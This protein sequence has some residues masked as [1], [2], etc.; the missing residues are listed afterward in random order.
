MKLRLFLVLWLA[1]SGTASAAEATQFRLYL[2]DGT[3]VVSYGEFAR[4]GDRVIFSFL[5]G[6]GAEPRLHTATLPAAAI[7]WART[8]RYAVSA[9]HQWYAQTRGEED[10]RRLSDEVATVLNTLVMTRDGARALDMA[11]QVR[12]TLAA[13]PREHYGYRERDVRDILA[14]LDEAIAAIRGAAGANS[15]EVALVAEIP[16]TPLEPVATM[17][18][19]SEQVGQA[20]GVARLTESAAERVALYQS[21]LQLLADEGAVLPVDEAASFRKF[22]ETAIRTEQA[23][24][25]RYSGMTKRLMTDAT[26]AAARAQIADVRR[27]LDRIPREDTRL[28]RKRPEVVQ[29][30][31]ASVQGQI[32]AAM[33]LRLLRDQWLIRRSLYADYQ[34]LVGAQI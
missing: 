31:H 33:R 14:V 8:D 15:F 5:M 12:A 13:W 18:S 10:F 22:A 3:T 20:F 19:V 28:G 21:V 26:R 6:S 27:V 25:A 29:A 34:R 32:D 1:L 2:T 24:D 17:P 16:V 11:R 9:R 30:L 23:I 4:V 7:D